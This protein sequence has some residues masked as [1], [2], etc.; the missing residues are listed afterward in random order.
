[1]FCIVLILEKYLSKVIEIFKVAHNDNYF[2]LPMSDYISRL[3]LTHVPR[4]S[5]FI[6]Q[7]VGQKVSVKIH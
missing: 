2:R 5:V 6:R 3:D 1:M 4:G 7:F